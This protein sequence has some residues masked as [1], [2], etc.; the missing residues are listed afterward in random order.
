MAGFEPAASCQ[1]Q[2][3][4][5]LSY[6]HFLFRD[7]RIPS[8]RVAESGLLESHARADTIRLAAGP[9]ALAG[10]LSLRTLPRIR[11]GTHAF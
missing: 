1:R 4:Y 5:S 3:L 2:A 8:T 6:M 11:T 10:S 7:N 9:G